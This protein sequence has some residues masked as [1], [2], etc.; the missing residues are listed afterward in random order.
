[1]DREKNTFHRFR[2]SVIIPT[3]NR[4]RWLPE[5]IRSVLAQTFPP[6]EIIVV[7]DG[8][9]D[10]TEDWLLEA[11]PDVHYH[12]QPQAGPSAAR[13][14]GARMATGNWLAFLDSDDR[15]LPYKLQR[16]VEFLCDHAEFQAVYTNEI[17]IRSGRR[18]NPKKRHQKYGGWIY[19]H[20]LPLCIISP[21]SILLSRELWEWSG[22]FDESL[23]ACEDYD[24]W[25]RIAAQHPIGY[26]DE[27]LIVKHGGHVDQLSRQWGLDRYRVRAL[28]K[29]LQCPE[30]RPDWREATREMLLQKCR[31]L[32]QGFEKHRRFAEAEQFRTILNRWQTAQ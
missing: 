2:I 13:N 23:P 30:L 15:W 17:W 12:W 10:G 9:T 7:D 3:F 4:R 16:Q 32:I 19:P 18:V 11:F 5:T 1:M 8:S 28:E 6:H 25:L 27:P 31:I 14:Q 29:M 21:S 24:L 26:I 20:C 22:G